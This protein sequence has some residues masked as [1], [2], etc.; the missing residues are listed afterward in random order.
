MI[1]FFNLSWWIMIPLKVH[2]P[3]SVKFPGLHLVTNISDNILICRW[4]SPG[5]NP[6][7]VRD[8]QLLASYSIHYVL[9]LDTP[10]YH[11]CH[12]W[13]KK[14]FASLLY[15]RHDYHSAS[16][17]IVHIW[18]SK[19]LYAHW[20]W[21]ELVHIFGCIYWIA[22]INS[23]PSALSWVPVFYSSS[24]MSY[25][26]YIFVFSYENV[27]I[28]RGGATGILSTWFV[29]TIQL[30]FTWVGICGHGALGNIASITLIILH[31]HFKTSNTNNYYERNFHAMFKIVIMVM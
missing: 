29:I 20:G 22:S 31:T 25:D 14:T 24:G 7:H 30:I 9:L 21:Q 2:A 13:Y 1:H 15:I 18:L 28:C 5:R 8:A 3:F 4:H 26:D 11:E 12:S 17:S 6:A 27:L 19:Q 16:N 10:N 23:S